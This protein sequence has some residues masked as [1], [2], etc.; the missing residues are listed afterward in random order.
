MT[1]DKLFFGKHKGFTYDNAQALA[2]AA[3]EIAVP[4]FCSMCGPTAGCGIYAFVKDGKFSRVAGMAECPINCGGVCVKGQAAP[5]WVYSP[6]RLKTP[7]LRKGPK[8][9]GD[10]QSI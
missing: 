7:L 10:F 5:E 6:D 8:G 1:N 4:T 3:G 2:Q 9:S